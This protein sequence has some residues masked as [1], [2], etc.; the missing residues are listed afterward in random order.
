MSY[1]YQEFLELKEKDYDKVGELWDFGELTEL[2]ENIGKCSNLKYLHINDCKIK[3]LPESIGNC[4]QLVALYCQGNQLTELPETLGNCTQ[5]KQLW[6]SGNPLTYFP[7][8]L[9]QIKGLN[10]DVVLP[11]L[12][13]A[14]CP[15]MK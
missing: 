13:V 9:E 11:Y 3:K 14:S 5:L 8:S 15:V 7:E 10:V 2:S 4:T 12:L 1:N 6:C